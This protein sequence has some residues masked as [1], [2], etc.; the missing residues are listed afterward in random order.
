MLSQEIQATIAM[1]RQMKAAAT[2]QPPTG[3]QLQEIRA[4]TDAALAQVPLPSTIAITEESLG[5]VEGESYRYTGADK[6]QG[7]FLLYFHGG[8]Y[9]NGSVKSRRY[10]ATG[11]AAAA[12]FDGYSLDYT[13][14]PKGKHPVALNQAREAFD[15]VQKLGY[16]PSDIAIAGESAGAMLALSLTL[17]L[18]DA[19]V[20][21][22]LAIYEGLFHTFQVMPSPESMASIAEIAAF[23]R[24]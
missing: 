4:A 13:Q 11:I 16:A 8:G 23:L 6:Q 15:Q 22:T 3:E 17:W 10:I 14:W 24:Q 2:G 5:P 12:G 7:R 20:P 21:N 18:K 19:H 1:L 9:E